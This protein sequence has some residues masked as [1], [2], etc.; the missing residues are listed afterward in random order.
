MARQARDMR[1]LETGRRYRAAAW[2]AWSLCA[3]SLALLALAGLLV[4]LTP[5]IPR[6][7][8]KV[9]FAVLFAVLSL[10]YPTVGAL[11]ASR[12]P[13]NSIGWIFCAA[14]LLIAGTGYATAYANYSI[15]ARTEPLPATQYAA[16]LASGGV[17]VYAT[18]LISALLLL[19]YPDGRLLSR[20]WQV[21]VWAVVVGCVTWAL[22]WSTGPGP[23]PYPYRSIDNPFVIQGSVGTVLGEWTRVSILLV[24]F[25][26]VAAGISWVYRWDR[27]EGR[28]R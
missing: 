26:W 10:T 5:P 28:E 20:G 23:L 1:G 27:A 17:L 16:W 25:G 19:L 21:T 3:I 6:A 22:S 13:R 7:E 15:F 18:L 4:Y 24:F 2:V 8:S 14:G 9:V 11:I 12:Q